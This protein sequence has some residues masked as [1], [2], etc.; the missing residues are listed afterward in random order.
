MCDVESAAGWAW[1]TTLRW[2][3]LLVLHDEE[4]LHV[5]CDGS[6]F[7]VINQKDRM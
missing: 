1:D 6:E 3:I 2:L 5:E 7:D 4:K